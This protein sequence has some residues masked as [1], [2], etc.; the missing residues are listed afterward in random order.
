MNFQRKIQ[1]K[2]KKNL[3]CWKSYW[4]NYI[5]WSEV[6]KNWISQRNLE[7]TEIEFTEK[8]TKIEFTGKTSYL[9]QFIVGE[10]VYDIELACATVLLVLWIVYKTPVYPEFVNFRHTNGKNSD[11]KVLKSEWIIFFTP[12]TS[13]RR[14]F[15]V[16]LVC[17]RN[18]RSEF[19]LGTGRNHWNS[20]QIEVIPVQT[21]SLCYWFTLNDVVVGKWCSLGSKIEPKPFPM[22]EKMPSIR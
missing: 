5:S 20:K 4:N 16:D 13:L 6:P 21:I 3:T 9:N 8:V 11:S 22:Q 14:L 19:I 2:Y 12:S 17:F 10:F 7:V 18:L 1:E 15:S